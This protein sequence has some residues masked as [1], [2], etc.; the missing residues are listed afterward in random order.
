MSELRTLGA[1]VLVVART[2]TSEVEGIAADLT[3]AGDRERIAIEVDRR[4]CALD[5][6]VNNAGMNIRKPWTQLDATKQAT[7][8]GPNRLAPAELLR[9]LHPLLQRGQRPFG[10]HVASVIASVD[11]GSGAAYALRKA[12]LLKLTRS[13]AVEWA[14]DVIRVNAETPLSPIGE[15][16]LTALY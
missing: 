12:A 5:L 9:Q 10:V 16:R 1:M 8:I 3:V 13:L 6:L 2:L 15:A 7:V 4:W 11:V 14:V